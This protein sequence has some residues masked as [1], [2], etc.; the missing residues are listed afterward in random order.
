MIY[1]T[2]PPKIS[3]VFAAYN[4]AASIER[5]IREFYEEIGTKIPVEIIIAEDGSTDGTKDILRR[6]SRELPIRLN[7]SDERRGYLAAVKA[8][9]SDVRTP[10]ALF[11]DS[12]GQCAADDFWKLWKN[13][14]KYDLVLGWRINRQDALYRKILSEGF[15][16][17]IR[18]LF[19]RIPFRDLSCPYMLMKKDVIHAIVPEIKYLK[20]GCWPEFL[21][22]V[23]K[24]GYS[25]LEVPINHRERFAGK[26]QV[27]RPNKL[28]YIILYHLFGALKLRFEVK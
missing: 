9:L 10:Y 8:G 3:I 24:R 15:Q 26:T 19:G 22:R 23:Y 25:M 6:L 7:M 11:A 20:H 14:D 4:E 18:I 16:I 12:D 17:I 13:K 5:V 21:V 2:N 27:F 28:L 1:L